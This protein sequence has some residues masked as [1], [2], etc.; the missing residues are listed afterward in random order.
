MRAFFSHT[1]IFSV[2]RSLTAA[3]LL[4]TVLDRLDSFLPTLKTANDELETRRAA[5]PTSVN[6][7]H[8]EDESAQHIEMVRAPTK[9]INIPLQYAIKLSSLSRS[10]VGRTSRAASTN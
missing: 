1:N 6:V 5:D 10:H 7:E 8:V 9:G 4:H 2:C 3:F